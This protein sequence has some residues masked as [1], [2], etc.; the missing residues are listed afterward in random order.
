MFLAKNERVRE[1]KEKGREGSR[2][3]NNE[4]VDVAPGW[5]LYK[6][7]ERE[8][9]QRE[10]ALGDARAHLSDSLCPPRGPSVPSTRGA[11]DRGS[12]WGSWNN[13]RLC[14]GKP[15]QHPLDETAASAQ[16]SQHSEP[17]RPT[18]SS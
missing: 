11:A 3:E 12:R 6:V 18:P 2:E 17:Q 9:N 13:P 5:S 4:R 16:L 15:R 7:E 1:R 10:E 8:G 14:R